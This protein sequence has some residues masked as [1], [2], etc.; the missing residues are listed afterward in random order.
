VVREEAQEDVQRLS[1]VQP[2]ED[3]YLETDLLTLSWKRGLWLMILFFTGSLTA[4]ALRQYD[5][6]LQAAEWAWLVMFIPLIISTGGN[7]GSQSATL[8]I[9]ALTAGEARTHDWLKIAGREI[10][11][12]LLLG[13]MLA[14]VGYIGALCLPSLG[15]DKLQAPGW[16]EA[17]V[18]PL[19]VVLVVTVGTVVGSLL[20]LLFRSMGLDPALMSNPFVAAISDLMGIVIY[21]NVAMLLLRSPLARP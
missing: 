16:Y 14:V 15:G 3:S 5:Q 4:I 21:M 6:H 1:A 19:T 2:L 12:G 20:P 17:M 8:I 13:A 10:A 18:V 11:M 9:S 7:S